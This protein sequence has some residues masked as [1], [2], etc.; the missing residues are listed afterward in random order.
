MSYPEVPKIAILVRPC[1]SDFSGVIFSVTTVFTR[2]TKFDFPPVTFATNWSPYKYSAVPPQ[3]NKIK[4]IVNFGW[5]LMNPF[6]FGFLSSS[7]ESWFLRPF[8][9]LLNSSSDD[10]SIK[11]SS[12]KRASPSSFLLSKSSSKLSWRVSPNACTGSTKSSWSRLLKSP[13]LRRILE[14]IVTGLLVSVSSGLAE[15]AYLL[16][17]SISG[18][19]LI[20]L[21]VLVLPDPTDCFRRISAC[22]TNGSSL[23]ASDIFRLRNFSLRNLSALSKRCCSKC[24]FVAWSSPISRLALGRTVRATLLFLEGDISPSIYELLIFATKSPSTI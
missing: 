9:L 18:I 4:K 20:S 12:S 3:S 22:P 13:I 2:S 5:R 19:A 21:I 8:F 11:F 15:L 1:L 16:K 6:F 7:S 24:C 23:W 17:A 10:K 14:V